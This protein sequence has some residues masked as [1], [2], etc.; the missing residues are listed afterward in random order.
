MQGLGLGVSHAIA[1]ELPEDLMTAVV[2]LSTS[3]S[4]QNSFNIYTLIYKN[5]EINTF[6]IYYNVY[7][8][9]KP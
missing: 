5:F 9:P 3:F 8:C 6:G 2:I 1:E 4:L 7:N